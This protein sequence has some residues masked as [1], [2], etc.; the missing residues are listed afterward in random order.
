MQHLPPVQK[1]DKRKDSF[2][3]NSLHKSLKKKG[4]HLG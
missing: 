2:M 4:F 3:V 1:Q